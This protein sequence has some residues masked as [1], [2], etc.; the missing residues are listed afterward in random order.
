MQQQHQNN[1]KWIIIAVAFIIL[2]FIYRNYNP[3]NSNYFLKCPFL[4]TTGYKC[5]GCGSQRAVH[6][7]LNFD[8]KNAIYY[9]IFLVVTIPYILL[10]FYLE[11]RKK[12]S[13]KLTKLHRRLYGLKAIIVIF[14]IILLFWFIRNTPIW[15]LN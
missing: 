13:D 10:G 11:I 2:I 12:T 1:I 9:N 8:I 5:A 3:S 14:I 7:L 6:A 4:Y 15:I